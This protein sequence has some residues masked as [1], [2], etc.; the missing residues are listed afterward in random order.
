MDLNQLR[1]FQ[2]TARTGNLSKAAQE[3]FVTQ[4]NL[5]RSIARLEEELGV[6]LFHHRKGKVTLNEYG[7]VFLSS[8]DL[9]FEQLHEGTQAIRRL[10]ESNQNILA[11]AS[12]IDDFLPDVLKDF[13]QKYPE[14]GIRQ[15]NCSQELVAQRLLD[16]TL[17]LALSSRPIQEDAIT[18]ELLGEMPYALMLRRDHPLASRSGIRVAE[19][20][21]QPFICDNSR[22]ALPALRRICAQAGFKPHVAYEVE[23]SDLIYQLLEGGAGIAFL[24]VSQYAKFMRTHESCP[25]AMLPV[26]DELPNAM[27]GVAFRKDL[28]FSAAERIFT[29]FVRDWLAEERR[30]LDAELLSGQ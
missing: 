26:L 21:D 5:S 6:P 22:M 19:L 15:F 27:I 7:R 17:T 13:S 3:L 4:P 12:T 16:R 29:S 30:H 11:L 8:V 25:L 20:S 24:P 28:T 14:I 18:F 1:Y 23:S 9:A 10:Y 2:T